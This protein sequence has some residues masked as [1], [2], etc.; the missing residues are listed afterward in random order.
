MSLDM[1]I[2]TVEPEGVEPTEIFYWRKFNPL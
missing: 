2:H 1:Y